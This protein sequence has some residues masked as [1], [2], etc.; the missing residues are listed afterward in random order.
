MQGAL[1]A[2]SRGSEVLPHALIIGL[3]LFSPLAG[4]GCS[5]GG[6][7]SEGRGGLGGVGGPSCCP[8]GRSGPPEGQRLGQLNLEPDCIDLVWTS[9][10][11]GL[12][13]APTPF[14]F[15]PKTLILTQRQ[16][17]PIGRL[18]LGEQLCSPSAKQR[19]QGRSLAPEAL[20][21]VLTG[22]QQ[23]GQPTFF[24]PKLFSKCQRLEEM[25]P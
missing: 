16:D 2:R 1:S 11:L 14:P 4:L 21:L 17:L 7:S 19:Q 10:G 24:W 25:T 3:A 20:V 12:P 5:C 23:A 9:H 6:G 22:P 8:K 18:A 13:P 15:P